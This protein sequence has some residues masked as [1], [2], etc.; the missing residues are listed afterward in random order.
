MA[1]TIH[2]V[3]PGCTSNIFHR[4]RSDRVLV[5]E[6]SDAMTRPEL[7]PHTSFGGS[8]DQLSLRGSGIARG[9]YFHVSLRIHQ[10]T[11]NLDN[12]WLGCLRMCRNLRQFYR[13]PVGNGLS[14]NEDEHPGP[15]KRI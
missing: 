14:V 8:D 11:R 4:E 3:D 12:L 2:L 15:L 5:C 9:A 7:P 13:A 10:D 1:L 6:I